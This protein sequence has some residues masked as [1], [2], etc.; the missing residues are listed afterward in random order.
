MARGLATETGAIIQ[1]QAAHLLREAQTIIESTPWTNFEALKSVTQGLAEI[2]R[3]SGMAGA[4]IQRHSALW[5]DQAKAYLAA[6]PWTKLSC[7]TCLS[8]RATHITPEM[9]LLAAATVVLLLWAVIRVWHRRRAACEGM[10]R[11]PF[12]QTLLKQHS[13]DA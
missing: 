7:L 8:Q 3:H 10:V 11:Q 13:F 12:T 9:A 6:Q 1:K 2:R 4:S 5:L